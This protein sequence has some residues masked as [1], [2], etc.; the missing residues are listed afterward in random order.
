MF[1]SWNKVFHPTPEQRKQFIE[2]INQA[3]QFDLDE[4]GK[5]CSNCKHRKYVQQNQFYDYTTC[6]FDKTVELAFGRNT[7]RHCCD[8][9]E[10]VGFLGVDE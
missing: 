1:V 4:Q 5:G 8:K 7:E 3:I 2:L 10:F 6:K 9:Y